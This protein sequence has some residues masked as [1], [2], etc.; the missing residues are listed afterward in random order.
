MDVCSEESMTPTKSCLQEVPE[1]K[2]IQNVKKS[3]L[4]PLV[5]AVLLV[6]FTVA[7]FNVFSSSFT[8]FYKRRTLYQ[9]TLYLGLYG[10]IRN[11]N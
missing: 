1:S 8:E 3:E 2:W 7:V 4:I 9:G 10:I 6:F 11:V 5:F